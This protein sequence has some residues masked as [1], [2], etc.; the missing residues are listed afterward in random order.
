MAFPGHTMFVYFSVSRNSAS[1][2]YI[3][4]Q[5]YTKPV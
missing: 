5:I 3:A 2:F 4:I 1:Q